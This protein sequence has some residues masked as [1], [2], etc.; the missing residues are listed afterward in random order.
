MD[1]NIKIEQDG[2]IKTGFI[3]LTTETFSGPLYG[4]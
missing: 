3:W 2:R 1:D 4:W